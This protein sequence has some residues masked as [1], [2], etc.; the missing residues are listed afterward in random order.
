[1]TYPTEHDMV[2][3]TTQ[4][5][6]VAPP[7]H[8]D[9]ARVLRYAISQHG[10][11]YNVA[12]EPQVTVAAMAIC[13]YDGSSDVYLFD[14]TTDWEVVGDADWFSVEEAMQ[15][16]TQHAKRETLEWIIVSSD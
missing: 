10:A 14:C 16:A 5:P 1:M 9:G 6:M 7:S 3:R 13:R 15:I 2:S 12:G 11:F 4:S 8:L